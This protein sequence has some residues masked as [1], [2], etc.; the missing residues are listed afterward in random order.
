NYTAPGWSSLAFWMNGVWALWN[1]YFA[2]SVV[3]HSLAMRQRRDDHRFDEHMPIEVCVH[4]AG[5]RDVIPAMT[6]D[7]NAAGLAFRA[8]C[9]VEDDTCVSITL[10]LGGQRV[11]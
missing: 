11:K 7:L 5:A 2:A 10:P 6:A 4:Q 9:R 8:T 1:C 3:R